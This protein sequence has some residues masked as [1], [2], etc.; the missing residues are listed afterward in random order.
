MSPSA[1]SIRKMAIGD[2]PGVAR[3]HLEGFQG[4]RS[5]LLGSRFLERM[6]LWFVTDPAGFGL[7]AVES[8][9]VVGFVAGARLGSGPAITRFTLGETVRAL[10]TRPWLL[11]HPKIIE[12]MAQKLVQ[13]AHSRPPSLALPGP[14]GLATA[15]LVGIA[16]ATDL[17][18]LGL[19]SR[20]L[21]AFEAV[22]VSA[23]YE[24]GYLSVRP[25]NVA[26]RRAYERAGWSPAGPGRGEVLNYA[27]LLG[28]GLG[29]LGAEDCEAPLG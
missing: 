11:G 7:V 15:S 22:A 29:A 18:S 2:L 16:V 4:Y 9:E 12:G 24:R 25:E 1:H 17:K 27:K 3:V 23:G 10:T 14:P 8:A 13:A 20:L 26:A 21:G 5:T 19:G 6:Y 28:A